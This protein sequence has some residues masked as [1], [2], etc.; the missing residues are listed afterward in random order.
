MMSPHKHTF[1]KQ[2]SCLKLYST[3]SLHTVNQRLFQPWTDENYSNVSLPTFSKCCTYHGSCPQICKSIPLVSLLLWS[4]HLVE[5]IF[6]FLRWLCK[7]YEKHTRSHTRGQSE[8]SIARSRRSTHVESDLTKRHVLK[9]LSKEYWNNC[10][11]L[12][13]GIEFF[14]NKFYRMYWICKNCL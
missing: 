12:P 1:T 2:F 4:T 6:Y 5:A 8:E 13:W 3:I 7:K 11:H 9:I 10:L 14:I